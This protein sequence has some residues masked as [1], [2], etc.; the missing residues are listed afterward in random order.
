M[1]L[2]NLI[3][4]NFSTNTPALNS[5]FLMYFCYLIE[6]FFVVSLLFF[7]IINFIL[8]KTSYDSQAKSL[9]ICAFAS[10]LLTGLF[11]ITMLGISLIRWAYHFIF[12]ALVKNCG[13]EANMPPFQYFF[14]KTNS[15]A[16]LSLSIG[17]I[18]F[19]FFIPIIPQSENMLLNILYYSIIIFVAIY[20]YY[21][22]FKNR[23]YI[24][25]YK[26]MYPNW[27]VKILAIISPALLGI[28]IAFLLVVFDR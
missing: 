24:N 12:S 8:D 17:I 19:S 25:R 11:A 5:K 7:T 16:I 1:H 23:D 28:L 3:S 4:N 18:I 22:S 9:I 2:Y 13:Q 21:D 14:L 6:F 15:N 27:T 20:A 26:D 10:I